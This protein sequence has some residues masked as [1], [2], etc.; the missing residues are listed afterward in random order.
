MNTKKRMIGLMIGGAAL[1]ALV[2]VLGTA[3]LGGFGM[4]TF[5]AAA[6]DGQHL[7]YLNASPQRWRNDFS[8]VHLQNAI[9]HE[10]WD[11]DYNMVE[12]T[13]WDGESGRYL[14]ATATTRTA[15]GDRF[16]IANARVDIQ[17]RAYDAFSSAMRDMLRELEGYIE[18]YEEYNYD[19]GRWLNAVVRVPANKLDAFL[20]S[21]EE[22]GTVISRSVDFSDVTDTMIDTGSRLRALQA[23]E[24]A[25]LAVL[26]DARSVDDIIRVRDRL[27]R[28]RGEIE[29]YTRRLQSLHSQVD[30]STVRMNVSEVDRIQTPTA[31]FLP[32]AGSNFVLSIQNIGVGFRNFALWLFG[33]V[34]YFVLVAMIAVPAAVLVKRARKRKKAKKA[35]V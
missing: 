26:E 2:A 22:H 32:S 8:D 12:E 31:R 4:R 14:E 13:A 6:S 19:H 29:S 33:A 30:Y 23:E 25:L 21:L 17:T 10:S 9:M 3:V 5:G 28:V 34:P 7:S 18:T 11:M 27:A 24:E 16:L 20:E 35:A 15:G 1:L